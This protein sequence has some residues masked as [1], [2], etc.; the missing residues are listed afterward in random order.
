MVTTTAISILLPLRRVLLPLLLV[1]VVVVVVV[2]AVVVVV[3][4]ELVLLLIAVV[5]LFRIISVT[6][7]F[8]V[9]TEGKSAG[10][11]TCSLIL[12][13]YSLLLLHNAYLLIPFV[14]LT[15]LTQ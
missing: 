6:A 12:S 8:N 9:E 7:M 13:N 10:R 1:V 3:L 5:S 14:P 15:T 11:S 4:V 2:V